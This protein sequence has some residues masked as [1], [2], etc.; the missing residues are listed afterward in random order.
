MKHYSNVYVGNLRVDTV[1]Q[2]DVLSSCES[3]LTSGKRLTVYNAN[4]HAVTLAARFPD[5]AKAVNSADLVF[6]DGYGVYIASRL[7]G[8]KLPE[9]FTPPDWID[10]LFSICA[11]HEVGIYLLGALPGIA[12]EAARRINTRHHLRID[13]HHGYFR[14]ESMTDADIVHLIND[15]GAQVLIVGMGMPR[16]E[17]W[18]ALYRDSLEPKVVLTVGA[19][20][21]YLAGS[22]PRAPRFLTDHGLEWLSRLVIEPR[23]LWKRYLLGLPSFVWLILQQRLHH[24]N[25][26]PTL[27]L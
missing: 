21:D 19:L 16:Q 25:K 7:L 23:R 9:R 17:L 1:T 12:D 27:M 13:F 15:S 18:S 26:T 11:K 4:A 6:C 20:I 2:A 14:Q 5:F 10:E 22:I 8:G 3:A 24:T